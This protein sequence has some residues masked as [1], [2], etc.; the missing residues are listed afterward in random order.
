MAKL[1]YIEASPRKE[2]SASIAVAKEFLRAYAQA[3]PSDTIETLDLWATTIP[4][5]DGATINAKYNVL[6]GQAQSDA[7]AK[8]W[9]AVEK[10]CKH[11]ISADKYVFSLP[12]WNFGIP[13]RL[14]HFIDV[15]VQP[16]L[17]FSFSPEKGYNGLVVGKP[18]VVIYASGGEYGS[19]SPS[20]TYDFQ[21]PYMDLVLGFIGISE[22]KSISVAP[23][24]AAPDAVKAVH[25]KAKK[26]AA[27]LAARF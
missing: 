18:A 7:E 8:A 15:L 11:F 27:D 2:R 19:G 3:H 25:E 1:L 20:M 12:M 21:K 23:T 14:K 10:I 5:F 26:E 24:L 16:G 9:G 6:H 17:T 13:Y 22:V 4:E